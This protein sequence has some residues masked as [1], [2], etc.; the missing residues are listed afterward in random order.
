MRAAAALPG[1][2]EDDAEIVGDRRAALGAGAA[3]RAADEEAGGDVEPS[4]TSSHSRR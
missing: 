3:F 4:R 1:V 2:G